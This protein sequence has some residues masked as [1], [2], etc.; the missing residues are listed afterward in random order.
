M[1]R[2]YWPLHAQE[3]VMEQLQFKSTLP[4]FSEPALQVVQRLSQRLVRMRQYPEIVALGYWLRKANIQQ[5]KE[6]WEHETAGRHIRA[7]G[8]VFHI[9]PSNVDTIFVYSWMLSMLAGNRNIIRISSQ[10]QS[11]LNVL[12][13]AIIEELNL[14]PAQEIAERT[15]ILTYPHNHEITAQISQI[16]HTRVIWGGDATVNTIRKIPL[17]PLANEL[18][19]PHRFSM[20]L[21]KASAVNALSPEAVE[22][23]AEQ[24]YN[25]A[26]WFDQMACS[27]PRLVVWDGEKDEVKR[28]QDRFWEQVHK[29][30][31]TKQYAFSPAVQV[32]K[33]TTSLLLASHEEVSTIQV[34]S[35]FSRVQMSHITESIRERHC[36]G[37][38]FYE[39]VIP[40]ARSIG[41]LVTDQDQTLTYYGYQQDE[42]LEAIAQLHTRG[43]DRIVPVGK[44]LDFQAVWDGQSFLRSLTREIVMI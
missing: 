7:R 16:C 18:A 34:A 2:Y 14:S 8:T 35:A 23:V 29:V 12:L 13:T 33:L 44:A 17:S 11:Q 43:I 41:D 37:G 21:L 5:L 6:A 15:M 28:A 27:S 24:F 25:D 4:P 3:D 20:T 31:I 40:D 1:I 26:F 39:T 32:Q 10:S 19:F 9:A 30:M 22:K 42:L 38:L 36:G